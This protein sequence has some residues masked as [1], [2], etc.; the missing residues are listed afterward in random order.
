M[1]SE[2]STLI[3]QIIVSCR[4]KN[5]SNLSSSMVFLWFIGDSC[6]FVYNIKYKTPL[7]MIISGG[8]QIFLDF[9]CF[10]QILCYKDKKN[11]HNNEI[12]SSVEINPNIKSKQVQQINLFMNK[13]EEKID[14]D[15]ND[16]NNNNQKTNEDYYKSNVESN[17]SINKV[18]VPDKIENSDKIEVLDKSR[19]ENIKYS[20]DEDNNDNDND[21]EKDKEENGNKNKYD[22]NITTQ[23]LKEEDDNKKDE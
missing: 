18:E 9:F 16:N 4:T 6:K 8:F 7:Q 15:N 14:I 17:K 21:K 1:T 13:L 20:S 10:M 2:A 3:P 22:N 5:A 12:G 23:N 11:L 19:D